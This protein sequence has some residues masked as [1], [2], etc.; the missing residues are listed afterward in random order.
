MR[1]LGGDVNWSEEIRR[2]LEE[3]VRELRRKRVLEEARRVIERLPEALRGT[4]A[5]YVRE[6][7]DSG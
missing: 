4:A 3:R 5:G 2:F 6:D 7:R 1:R